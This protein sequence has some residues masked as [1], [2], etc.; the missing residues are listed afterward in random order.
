MIEAKDISVW[1]NMEAKKVRVVADRGMTRPTWAG[2][3]GD[4]IGAAY[5]TWKDA[6]N[7]ERVQLMLE[8]AIEL[9]MRGFN[10]G[11]VLREFAKVKQFRNLG[12][13]SYPMCRALTIAL[14]G[15]CRLEPNTMTFDE[16]MKCET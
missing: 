11:D 6:T 3:W 12:N 16:I 10:L 2:H 1:V 9:V 14:I 4:P 13:K 5:S 7:G 15:K 8:T